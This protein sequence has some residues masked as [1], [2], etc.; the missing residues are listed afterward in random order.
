MLSPA[1]AL[2]LDYYI[3]LSSDDHL[4]TTLVPTAPMMAMAATTIRPAISAY[5]STSPPCS[6]RISF[7]IVA[8]NF[9][10]TQLLNQSPPEP[11]GRQQLSHRRARARRVALLPDDAIAAP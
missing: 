6:S 8:S 11:T 10:M 9:F 7:P 2:A 1:R 5:S 4:A 3:E